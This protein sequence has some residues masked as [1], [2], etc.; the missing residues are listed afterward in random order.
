MV[1]WHI[2]IVG[3]YATHV[4]KPKMAITIIEDNNNN[5]INNTF[6]AM[7]RLWL[8]YN[9][10]EPQ[11][12]LHI[13]IYYYRNFHVLVLHIAWRMAYRYYYYHLR[14]SVCVCV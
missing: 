5:D 8:N 4:E 12:L 3:S 13:S 14:I 1:V 6:G 11:K 2:T 9:G 7:L 10:E